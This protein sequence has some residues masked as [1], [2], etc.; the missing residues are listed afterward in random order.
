MWFRRDLRLRT[1]RRARRGGRGRRRV[2]PLFVLDPALWGPA[3][4]ARRAWL[5]RSLRALDAQI[6]GGSSCATATRARRPA[7]RARGRR[8]RGARGADS[9]PYGRRR[10]EAV[11]EALESAGR[12][13]PDR[14]ALRRRARRLLKARRRP[15]ASSPRSPGLAA[16][17][18][19]AARPGVIADLGARHSGEDL[20]PEPDLGDTGAAA[21]RRAGRARTLA[22]FLDERLAATPTGATG[23]A[24]MGHRRC[25]RTS[26]TARCTRAR[27]SPTWRAAGQRCRTRSATSSAGGSS[28]PT[29][30][31][32]GRTPRGS[33]FGRSSRR[34]AY[35]EPG[36]TAFAAWARAVRDS[37][38]ST[39]GCASCWRRAGCTI[40]C[41]WSWRP[42][43]SRTCTSTG[44]TARGC[45]CSSCATATWRSN[46]HGW[47]W[48]AGRAPTRRRTSGSSTP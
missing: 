7:R 46:Q 21:G 19:A 38:S 30:S 10:D 6:A 11:E 1:I 35:D 29:C 18:L 47:Q 26:S 14:L 43:S 9:G 37:R 39:P 36:P 4:P 12:A 31:C 33:T 28:T 48:V 13:G 34:C 23:P 5:V 22:R 45:S 2:V 41:G 15:T 17:R 25:R 42:S 44:S 24:L 8:G 20:P 27:C 3:G 40:G 32:T 16:A